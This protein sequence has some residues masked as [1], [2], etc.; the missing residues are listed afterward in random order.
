MTKQ[1]LFCFLLLLPALC[2]MA[3][4]KVLGSVK[5]KL[6]DTLYKETLAEATISV[7]QSTD[8]TV[9]GFTLSN[10]KGEFEV[11]GLD[12]G[13][14]RLMVSFQGYRHITRRFR[15]TA[16]SFAIN[17]GTLYMDKNTTLLEEVVVEGPPIMIKKD[18]VEFRANAFRTRPNATAEDL[19]KKVPGM[20]VDKEGNV[21]AQGEDVKKIYVDGKEFFGN[22]PKVATKNITADMIE[23][24]QVFDDMSDQAK[25]TRIDDGSRSK[26][27]N[28]KLKKDKKKGYFGRA[29]IGGGSDGRYEGTLSLN[30]FEGDR[31]LSLVGGSNNVNKPTFSY[32]DISG[33]GGGGPRGGGGFGGGGFGGGGIRMG[34]PGGGFGGGGFGGGNSTGIIKS[35]SA[36]LNYSDKLT[37]KIELTGSYFYNDRDART[38]QERQRLTTF[39]A[40]SSSLQH[41]FANGAN[42]TRNHQFNLRA[43]FTIDSMNSLLLTSNGS[44]SNTD[45]DSYDSLIN[46]SVQPN[47]E[48]I[49]IKGITNS[50]QQSDGLNVNSNLLYRR[51]FHRT[52]RTLTIGWQNSLTN[53]DGTTENLS[54]LEYYNP[55]GSLINIIN[56]NNQQLQKIRGNNNTISTSYTEPIGNNKLLEV[57]YAYTRNHNTSN[58][59]AFNF[60]GLSGK[61]DSVNEQL[62][63]YFENDFYAHRAGLNFRI[64][65][66][67]YS[68]QIG[69]AVSLSEQENHSIQRNG[70]KDTTI[71]QHFTNFFPT[72]NFTY[73]FARTKVLRIFYRGR[74]NQPSTTQ[75]QNVPDVSNLLQIRNGNPGLKQEFTNNINVNFNSFNPTTFKYVS[76]NVMFNNTSNKIVNS[77]DSV[78]AGL[79]GPDSTIKGAQYIVPVNLNGSYSATMFATFGIPLKG[80]LKGSNIS[81]NS[82]VSYNRD[83]SLLYK[84]RNF[85]NTLLLGQTARASFDFKQVAMLGV[86]ATVNYNNVKYSVKTNSNQDQKYFTQT[87]G[88]DFSYLFFQRLTV[89]TDFDYSINTGRADGF[90][91]Q[92]PLWSAYAALQVFKNKNGEIRFSVN[93]ILNQNQSINRTVADNYIEDTRTVVLKRYFMLTFTYN[94]NRM[95][96]NNTQRSNNNMPN[97]PRGMQRQ[98]RS[99]N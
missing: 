20:E 74:T 99:M 7:M 85:T 17:L 88:I 26:T 38:E 16:D 68:A 64:Q 5:G 57:N 43:E 48:Y 18:T 76:V 31:R 39:K 91:Q 12:T 80:N 19:L 3:Q 77:I 97:M 13:S 51:R 42:R 15:I 9:A 34:R 84:R 55:D 59:R 8:S 10:A 58:S 22:D 41:E 86:N 35:T 72:A 73:N 63:N 49:A 52:G 83:A 1:L 96:G 24:V 90:N 44:F 11:N 66:P 60:N 70:K 40:D 28:I 81:F 23:S 87:Y 79:L 89:A 62:T 2:G 95:G 29:V 30:H 67:K 54:P 27:I 92:V 32:S 4:K 71:N 65:N 14:Y 6:A 53:T 56:Q 78:P 37:N 75:L 33:G 94:L 69:G 47:L 25:F 98:M 46:R 45:N 50:N 61:Y 36:G 93:D 21:K 82:N